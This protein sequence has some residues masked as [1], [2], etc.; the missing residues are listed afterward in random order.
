M[1][2]TIG[3]SNLS[4]QAFLEAL[5]DIQTV[6][7]VR[8]H[9]GSIHP[10]FTREAMAIWLPAAGKN[11]V[12]EP[13]LGGWRDVHLSLQSRFEPFGVDLAAYA[14]QKFPKQRIARSMDCQPTPSWTNMGF[15]DYQFFMTLSEFQEAALDLIH[16]PESVAYL[17]CEAVWYRCHRSM[18]ADYLYYRGV[19][20]THLIP[21]VTKTKGVRN[22]FTA[23]AT[24]IGNRL[25]R[26]HPFVKDSW[27]T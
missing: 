10:H 3:H 5:G 2:Y 4:Q 27:L 9:P 1:L 14:Q 17:C 26:Y 22:S 19:D 11:Y 25:E 24:V 21:R 12:W 18:I 23:H 7:D 6:M 16:R 15:W 13:R 20:S 8:S